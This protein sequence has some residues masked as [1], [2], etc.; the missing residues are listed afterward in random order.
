MLGSGSVTRWD[1]T[2]DALEVTV[3][4]STTEHSGPVL[5]IRFAPEQEQPRQDF[6]HQ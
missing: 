5:R 4:G 2:P 6:L 3:S 1:R